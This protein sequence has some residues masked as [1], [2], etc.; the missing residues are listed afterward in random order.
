MVATSFVS[1]NLVGRQAELRQVGEI[2]AADGDLILTGV[3]G[4]G[5][6]TLIRWAAQVYGAKVVEIDCLRATDY[7][8]FLELLA[9][10][11]LDSF[12]SQTEIS[13]IQRWSQ[14]QPLTLQQ[15]SSGRLRFV[16]HLASGKEW[17]LFQALLTLPQVLAEWLEC[18]VVLVLQN[19]SHIRS[20]DRHS[21]WEHYLR[22]E[23]QQQSRVSYVLVTTVAERWV[24]QSG[25]QVV[26]LGPLPDRDLSLWLETAS[27]GLKFEPDA[28]TL[29][30]SYVQGHFGDTIALLR[31]ISEQVQ[32]EST[33]EGTKEPINATASAA[34]QQPLETKPH[35]ASP[36]LFLI[37]PHHVHRSTL[38][39]VED[40]SVT[41]ESLIF[42]AAPQPSAGARKPC[43]RPYR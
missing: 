43:P 30:L 2:L 26:S 40:L 11:F 22:H 32:S 20:W 23:I 28:I 4:I 18:R 1:Q 14:N 3:P 25:L 8:R 10:G 24:Q 17:G 42:F 27:T 9:E 15:A 41:F 33:Q 35:P 12:E 13:L 37:Q 39:L 19:F 7:K 29:F 5:R 16:W 38:A 34:R 21:K 36:S 6:R 31:R